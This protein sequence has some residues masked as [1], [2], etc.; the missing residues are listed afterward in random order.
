MDIVLTD[1]RGVFTPPSPI[2]HRLPHKEGSYYANISLDALHHAPHGTVVGIPRSHIGNWKRIATLD[3][4]PHYTAALLEHPTQTRN[5]IVS[6]GSAREMLHRSS[7]V[8]MPNGE[9]VLLSSV[10][11]Y[12]TEQAITA[13]EAAGYFPIG[14][15]IKHTPNPTLSHDTTHEMVFVGTANSMFDVMPQSPRAIEKL[16][17]KNIGVKIISSM[18]MQ[19]SKSIARKIGILASEDSCITG[20]MLASI[21]DKEAREYISHMNIFSELAPYDIPRITRLLHETGQRVITYEFNFA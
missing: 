13:H 9:V 3:T 21:S 11:R 1:W 10:L 5:I 15:A 7:S 16:H 17:T 12:T 2:L 20:D 14:I 19:L 8:V 18:P 6:T 4:H